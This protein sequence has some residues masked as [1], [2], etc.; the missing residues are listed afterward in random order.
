M[1]IFKNMEWI[2]NLKE[3]FIKIKQNIRLYMYFPP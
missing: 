1:P 3:K 2:I